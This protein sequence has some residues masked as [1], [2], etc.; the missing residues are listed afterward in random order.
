MVDI[1]I[2]TNLDIRWKQRFDNFQKAYLLLKDKMEYDGIA[3]N[4]SPKPVINAA[5][6]ANY[7]NTQEVSHWLEMIDARNDTLHDYDHK[8]F[9]NI[10]DRIISV[11]FQL[12]S[13]FYTQYCLL[14]N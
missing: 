7:I 13:N 11:Y 14:M 4:I 2:N 5:F 6:N 9:E 3:S 8:K 10:Y 12:F 1:E